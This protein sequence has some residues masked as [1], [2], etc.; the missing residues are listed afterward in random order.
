MLNLFLLRHGKASKDAA[1]GIDFDRKLNKKGTAQCNQIGYILAEKELVIDQI[2]SSGAAR[3]VETAEIINHYLKSGPISFH[4]DLYLAPPQ[5]IVQAISSNGKGKNVLYVG[6]NFGISDVCDYLSG[7]AM[8]LSTSQLVH[9]SF[10][11]DDWQLVSKDT[12]AFVET[13]VPDVHSF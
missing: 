3:T 11:F 10:D 1:S 5:K 7:H 4:D 9:F 8:S 2:I 12:A 13:I 6:H